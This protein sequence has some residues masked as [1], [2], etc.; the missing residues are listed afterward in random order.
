MSWKLI[1][2]MCD[3]L[4]DEIILIPRRGG[5][6]LRFYGDTSERWRVERKNLSFDIGHGCLY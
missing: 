2:V 1:G 5:R 6:V 3:N 4:A